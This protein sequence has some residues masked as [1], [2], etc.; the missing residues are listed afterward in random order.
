MRYF[1]KN[2]ITYIILILS[3]VGLSQCQQREVN[4]P[5]DKGMYPFDSLLVSLLDAKK[6]P[7]IAIADIDEKYAYEEGICFSSFD[8]KLKNLDIK[9]WSNCRHSTLVVN[10][11]KLSSVCP[12]NPEISS[13]VPVDFKILKETVDVFIT[14]D[15]KSIF[16]GIS[17]YSLTATGKLDCLTSNVLIRSKK[18]KINAYQFLGYK[19]L[20]RSF[21][22]T[23]NEQQDTV[24]FLEIEI[25]DYSTSGRD[26]L[27]TYIIKPSTIHLAT[28]KIEVQQ[29]KY[30]QPKTAIITSENYYNNE[31]V[32]L[33]SKNW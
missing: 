14:T 1:I 11:E 21:Y 5:F 15:D 4:Q 25:T 18:D 17:G 10:G 30:G 2:L 19:N 26:S 7:S 12:T 9:Y 16:W 32:K 31:F 22:W 23:Y 8:L 28:N 29:N 20:P 27:T 6:I 3:S 13:D 33:I 24:H